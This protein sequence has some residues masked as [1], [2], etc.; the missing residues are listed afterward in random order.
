MD[1]K[2]NTTLELLFQYQSI[3]MD[4]M[5]QGLCL[6]DREQRVVVSNRQYRD[7]Y[8]L[9]E[10]Q[11]QPGTTLE[12]ICRARIARGIYSGNDPEAYV[13]E[14]TAPFSDGHDRTQRLTDGRTIFIRRRPMPDGGW[15]TTHEDITDRCEAEAKVSF[16]ALHDGLTGLPNRTQFHNRIEEMLARVRRGERAGLLSLDLDHFKSVND[17]YG[18]PV[19]DA[20]LQEVARRIRD[21]TRETDTAARL[22]GDEFAVLQAQVRTASDCAAL[23]QRLIS[24]LSE[25]YSISG[26]LIMIGVSVGIAIADQENSEAECLMRSADLALYS[27]K[28]EGRGT[29]RHFATE[30]DIEMQE[31]RRIEGDLRAALVRGEFQ[32]YYQPI[33]DLRKMSPCGFEALLRWNHPQF[34]VVPP[35]NF[36]PIA[37]ETG[38][39]L[40]ITEWVLHQACNDAVSWSRPLSVAVNL[41]AAHFRHGNPAQSVRSALEVSGLDPARLEVEITETLLLD[42]TVP[43]SEM[44]QEIKNMGV[45]ISMD[46]FGTG[47]SSLSYLTDFPF[48]KIK[49]DRSFVKDLPAGKGSLA[50]LRSIAGLGFS[51]GMTTTAEGVETDEQ[52]AVAISEGCSEVQGYYFSPPRPMDEMAETL[53]RC[54]D[55]CAGYQRQRAVSLKVV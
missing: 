44:L 32:L 47:Y 12:K 41:S 2:E 37:E 39:I 17:T 55:K 6:F 24:I 49:I 40:P 25:P 8:G 50:I 51:L 54:D 4:N 14:R 15:L 16:M 7:L 35:L 5:T 34:G 31:R 10:A 52:L 30:M 22:S 21:T 27:A 20:L 46:D 53:Q 26:H 3:A 36:I 23:A 33:M 9:T 43:I 13:A 19:G 48:D 45:R 38:L 29:Y 28:N 11:V 18:H 42:K 1:H